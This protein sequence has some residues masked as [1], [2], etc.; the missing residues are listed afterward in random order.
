MWLG[1]L[2]Q[3]VQLAPFLLGFFF[4]AALLRSDF[5]N[6]STA[7]LAP[8]PYLA[9]MSLSS[10]GRFS[11]HTIWAH[12]PF[13]SLH[14]Q[15]RQNSVAPLHWSV[16]YCHP[17]SF[18]A[19]FLSPLSCPS[20]SYFQNILL[21]F[22]TVFH[23]RFCPAYESS[24]HIFDYFTIQMFESIYP[25]GYLWANPFGCCEESKAQFEYFFQSLRF[26]NSSFDSVSCKW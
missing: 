23:V 22:P 10:W 6:V 24:G 13:L 20:T 12:S 4:S 9:M 14:P 16:T 7:L 3:V 18:Q 5:C 8:A 17:L 21:L 11:S 26:P 1:V 15:G 2:P 25:R 19:A